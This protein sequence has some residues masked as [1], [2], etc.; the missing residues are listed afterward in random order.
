MVSSEWWAPSFLG[1]LHPPQGTIIKPSALRMLVRRWPRSSQRPQVLVQSH[2]W[3]CRAIPQPRGGRQ[4]GNRSPQFM[5]LGPDIAF[6]SLTSLPPR[7]DSSMRF[8]HPCFD[9]PSPPKYTLSRHTSVMFDPAMSFK[10]WKHKMLRDHQV[11][12]LSQRRSCIGLTLFHLNW[13]KRST[14]NG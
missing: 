7:Q 3:L 11:K 4:A 14:F 10:P 12:P 6:H 13:V 1:S 2:C 5:S 9:E 8:F